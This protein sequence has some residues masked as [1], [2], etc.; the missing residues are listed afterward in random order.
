MCRCVC[1][2]VCACDRV[3][4]YGVKVCAFCVNEVACELARMRVRWKW[5]KR[6]VRPRVSA[7]EQA[8]E[9]EIGKER[10]WRLEKDRDRRKK[11]SKRMRERT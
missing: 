3:C 7:R 9:G 2:S 6:G 8:I 1:G 5:K 4:V 10:V 11:K